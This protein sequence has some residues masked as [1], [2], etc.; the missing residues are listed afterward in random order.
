MLTSLRICNFKSWADTGEMRLAPIT[1][2][3]GTNSSGKTSILQLLLLLKQ[4]A[5]STDR[6]QVLNLGDER[7]LVSLGTFRDII[8]RSPRDDVGTTRDRSS[9]N[10]EFSW[11]LPGLLEVEDPETPGEHLFA[12]ESLSFSAEITQSRRVTSERPIVAHFA[13]RPED[14]TSSRDPGAFGMRRRSGASE[15]YELV[16]DQ[17]DFKRPRGRPRKLPAPVKCYGFPDEVFGYFL[18]SG[19]LAEL[20]LEFERNFS[21]TYYLGPLREYPRRQYTWAGGRPSDMGRRGERVVDALLASREPDLR[22]KRLGRKRRVTV[23]EVVAEWLKRLG[24]IHSFAVEAVAPGSSLYQVSVQLRPVSAR[25][26]ITDVGFGISQILPVIALCYYV[27]EG[28]TIILEQ[29]EIHLHPSVQAGLA[30][31]LIDA[32]QTRR[33][34]IILESHSE[35]LLTRLQRRIAEEHLPSSDAALYFCDMAE[36]G[37]SQLTPLELDVFGNIRNWPQGFFGDELGE[38]SAMVRA[39]M[40]RRMRGDE[41]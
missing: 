29:P 39:E 8:H 21:R 31:V 40:E 16:A 20:Q 26:L 5:E 13:Y 3:F 17:F 6:A 37:T 36:D 15:Q 33:V 4:T 41:L 28:S 1:G 22:I 25:V 23:E 9:V 30:D 24:L 34:Q 35:H 32:M 38:R 18:N 2:F 10:W 7:S 11:S 27:P 12:F 14:L 19:F